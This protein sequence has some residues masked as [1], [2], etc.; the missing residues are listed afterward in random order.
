MDIP[1]VTDARRIAL[2]PGDILAL[3]FDHMLDD[4]EIDEL[5]LRL[6][7]ALPH[8]KVL[9]LD[10]GTEISVISPEAAPEV[11]VEATAPVGG[12]SLLKAMQAEVRK[13]GGD[14]G[15]FTRKAPRLCRRCWGCC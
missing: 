13:A 5:Q 8:A 9:I 6:R 4:Q 1:E 2:K 7:A 15:M 14:P 10:P 11:V 12:S 3:R